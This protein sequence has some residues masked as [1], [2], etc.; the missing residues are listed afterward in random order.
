MSCNIKKE[1]TPCWNDMEEL[2]YLICAIDCC[3]CPTVAPQPICRVILPPRI[4]EIGCFIPSQRPVCCPSPPCCL[5]LLPGPC[6]PRP[7]PPPMC[8][9]PVPLPPPPPPRPACLPCCPLPCYPRTC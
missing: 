5:P 9:L 4:Q 2:K 7:L 3:K 6:C 1:M 8:P